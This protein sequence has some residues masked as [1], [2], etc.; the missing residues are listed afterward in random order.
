MKLTSVFNQGEK[1]PAKYTADGENINPPLEISKIPS[2]TK[3]L[4]LVVDDPDAQRVVG[5]TWV[6]WV[7][8]NIKTANKIEENSIPGTP[9]ES[10]YKK[11]GYGGTNPPRGSGVHNYHFKL[12]A[13]D[14]ELDLK[15]GA[16]LKRIEQAMQN[17]ILDKAEFIGIYS[18]D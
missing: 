16:S 3:S 10:T 7:V 13:L 12:Y 15:N 11:P 2:E 4:V 1:I 8:F 9:G 18:R 14:A 17:H 6:H 5:Y